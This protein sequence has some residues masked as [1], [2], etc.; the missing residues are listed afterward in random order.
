MSDR[1]PK[2]SAPEEIPNIHWA[3][4]VAEDL[5]QKHPNNVC[6]VEL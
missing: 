6:M 2:L 1:N 3:D 4:H 5:I